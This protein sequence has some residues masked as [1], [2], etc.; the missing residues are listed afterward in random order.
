TSKPS[1][2]P[3]ATNASSRS[4]SI[5]SRSRSKRRT[6]VTI[7][8]TGFDRVAAA[9]SVP[10]PGT[11]PSSSC[12]LFARANSSRRR[13]RRHFSASARSSPQRR[14]PACSHSSRRSS[15]FGTHATAVLVALRSSSSAMLPPL[16]DQ[17]LTEADRDLDQS[18]ALDLE[19]AGD[20]G[21]LEALEHQIDEPA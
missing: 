5:R 2:R 1:S 18:P 6:T 19:L 8:R 13:A 21:P 15:P 11:P 16:L 3:S 9:V 12:S 14:F 10:P 17:R 4:R 7:A 20:L